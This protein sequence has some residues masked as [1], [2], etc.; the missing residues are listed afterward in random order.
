MG[1]LE[2]IGEPTQRQIL[3]ELLDADDKGILVG[4][5]VCAEIKGEEGANNYCKSAWATE[6]NSE[7]VFLAKVLE[8]DVEESIR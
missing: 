7:R 6:T 1:D 4:V 3:L 5:V 2:F 8:L